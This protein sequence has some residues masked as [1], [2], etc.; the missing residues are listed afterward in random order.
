MLQLRNFLVIFFC[1]KCPHSKI[2]KLLYDQYIQLNV[3]KG[4]IEECEISGTYFPLETSKK[5]ATEL[6][7]KRHFYKDIIDVIGINKEE[8]IYTFF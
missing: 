7:G 3:K 6:C 8:L 4:R 1:L 5:I 2:C